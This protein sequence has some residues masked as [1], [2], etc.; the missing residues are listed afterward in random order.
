MLVGSDSHEKIGHEC[1]QCKGHWRSSGA[2]YVTHNDVFADCQFRREQRQSR[3]R[4]IVMLKG[5][6]PGDSE[7]TVDGQAPKDG[8]NITGTSVQ[9]DKGE[10]LGHYTDGH[11]DGGTGSFTGAPGQIINSSTMGGWYTDADGVLHKGSITGSDQGAPSDPEPAPA[12]SDPEP[13]PAPSDVAPAPSDPAPAPAPSDPAPSPVPSD[14]A[15]APAPS[16][17]GPAPAPDTMPNPDGTGPVG[18]ASHVSMPNPDGSGPGGPS[19]FG[20]HGVLQLGFTGA[21]VGPGIDGSITHGVDGSHVSDIAEGLQSGVLSGV[22][23]GNGMA[24]F[25]TMSFTP[26]GGTGA[27]H[28]P[29]NGFDAS[30]IGLDAPHSVDL[31]NFEALPVQDMTHFTHH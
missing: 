15:P 14:P 13:A 18:P 6:R 24:S 4:G 17:P 27:D 28:G 26:S 8:T 23:G 22:E 31:A 11:A 9:Q 30:H 19:A 2:S 7:F 5:I 1:P 29:T 12:P 3:A 25:Q 16:D 10:I 20:E 21:G